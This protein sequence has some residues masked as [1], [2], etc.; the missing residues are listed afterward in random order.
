MTN[1]PSENLSVDIDEIS[2]RISRRE[3]PVSLI[4]IS[5]AATELL[6]QRLIT[7]LSTNSKLL[8][9]CADER[10]FS[11]WQSQFDAFCDVFQKRGLG[12]LSVAQLP[13]AHYWGSD[14]SVNPLPFLRQRIAALSLLSGSRPAVVITTVHALCALTLSVEEFSSMKIELRK[15]DEIDLDEL[16]TKLLSIGYTERNLIEEEGQFA[17]KGGVIDI[18]SPQQEYPTRVELFGDEIQSMRCFSVEDQ[19]SLLDTESVEICPALE[20]NLDL[21][22][23]EAQVQRIFD[24]LIEVDAS[25]EDRDGVVRAFLNGHHFREL[26]LFLPVLRETSAPC[27]SY[28]NPGDLLLSVDALEKAE[29]HHNDMLVQIHDQ[30]QFD[31]R[32]HRLTLDPL[33]HF[34]SMQSWRNFLNSTR[35]FVETANAITSKDRSVL[36]L[37]QDPPLPFVLTPGQDQFDAWI[38]FFVDLHGRD[39]GIV[40]VASQPEQKQRLKSLLEHRQLAFRIDD[41]LLVD[42]LATNRV[43]SGRMIITHGQLSGILWANH[44]NTIVIPD[45][46]LFGKRQQRQKSNS[47]KLKNLISSFRELQVGS[48]VVH[49]DHGIGRYLGLTT[50]NAGGAQIECLQLEYAG[51]DRIYLPVDRLQLLQRYTTGAGEEGR[52]AALDKLKGS[53]WEKRKSSVRKAVRDMADQLLRIQAQRELAR[54]IPLA[55]RSD[56]YFRFEAEFPYE[57]TDDQARAI[58]DVN[59]DVESLRPMDRLVCGDVGFGKTEVAMRAAFRAVESGFQVLVLVPT[60]V[61][62]YQHYR[63]FHERM[64][65]HGIRVGQLN[66][67]VKASD[68]KEVLEGLSKGSIDIVIGTHRLLSK[69]VRPKRLGLMIIDEEQ[70]FGVGHKET[71]KELRAGCHVLTLTAT[72]IPRTL[73]M[74]MLGLRDISIIATPPTNR[75]AVKTYISRWEDGLVKSAIESEASRGGQIFFVHNRIEDI[76]VVRK[77]LK[78]LAPDVDVRI[79][80]GQMGEDKLEKVILDFIEGRFSVLLCTTIIESGIDMPNVNTL[81]VNQANQF[82]LAQL[83]Q[84]RGRVGR[85][86]RQAYAYFLVPEH[87]RITDESRQ[88]LDVLSSYQQ[89]GSGFQVARHD[90]EIRGAGNLL[91]AEQSGRIDDVGLELYTEM[92]SMAI[93]DVRGGRSEE[94]IDTEIRINFSANIPPLF[95]VAEDQRLDI[96]KRLFTIE[97]FD[98]LISLR[99]ELVDRF[100]PIPDQVELLCRVAE[101]KLLLRSCRATIISKNEFNVCELRFASLSA[102]QI[103]S[104]SENVAR[105]PRHYQLTGDFRLMIPISGRWSNDLRDQL[106]FAKLLIDRLNPIAQNTESKL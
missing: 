72:P 100:G 68:S 35:N 104:L 103:Q 7:T 48:L 28:V 6:L 16:R 75:V 13:V 91:G 3:L 85:S 99:R 60:T 52:S 57:E 5:R 53:G 98:D 19:R 23:R 47:R 10:Q 50:L 30:F 63:S 93:A 71:L 31:R 41:E 67:F 42:L 54:G 101:M 88:R 33:N 49:V 24:Y 76:H 105:D 55:S 43:E 21:S 38:D 82:G 11:Q 84:I 106:V 89:L 58:A 15:G 4:G 14:R 1:D 17:V 62:C 87:E 96:Y 77:K 34:A 97:S 90:L 79:A 40:I 2:T 74:S 80:H 66:R 92:L 36:R 18:Y 73:H 69:D 9:I 26:P 59:A 22:H 94:R 29:D 32:Q 45:Y 44:G 64:H 51:G 25:S 27:F 83:Y 102:E 95:I 39:V 70:R 8:I 86:T 61:L 12:S 20:L 78:D 37:Q 56:N 81:I 65:L 46:F